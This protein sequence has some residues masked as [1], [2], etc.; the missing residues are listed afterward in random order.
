MEAVAVRRKYIL[1]TNVSPT[2]FGLEI[3]TAEGR[4][5]VPW[6][7]CSDRLANASPLERSILEL[8]PSGYGVHWP[9]LDEDLAVG[10][11]VE[12]RK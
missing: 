9:L 5:F 6:G 2:E 1:A 10:P 8:L 4:Y 7:E 11:L 3:T 12:G